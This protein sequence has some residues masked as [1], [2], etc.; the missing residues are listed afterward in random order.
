MSCVEGGAPEKSSSSAAH[1]PAC[2]GVSHG[3]SFL[4]PSSLARRRLARAIHHH[5]GPAYFK[6][7]RRGKCEFPRAIANA[8]GGNAARCVAS[9]AA[10]RPPS[11]LPCMSVFGSILSR[12]L[13]L[14]RVVG[15]AS[16]SLDVEVAP[17]DPRLLVV[18]S[19]RTAALYTTT[20][21]TNSPTEVISRG[22]GSYR[23][24]FVAAGAL[25]LAPRASGHTARGRE[26]RSWVLLASTGFRLRPARGA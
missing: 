2:R 18:A 20:I 5:H 25:R 21:A 4:A 9:T 24:L 3:A 6:P 12:S 1:G 23:V 17:R 22:G 16:A 15:S 13:G 14:L 19:S 7:T 11:L 26:A 8:R 10:S